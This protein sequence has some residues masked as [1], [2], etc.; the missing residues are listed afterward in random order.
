[1]KMPALHHE[2]FL[3]AGIDGFVDR[4]VRFLAPA[5]AAGAPALVLSSKAKMDRLRRALGA[6]AGAVEHADV[7]DV[8]RNPNWI[9]PVWCDFLDAHAGDER[10]WG[11]GEPA[12]AGRSPAQ[13]VECRH[14]EALVNVA[15]GDR[16]GVDLLC[17]YDTATLP[18]DV[19]EGACATH[20][21]VSTAAES[22]PS[23]SYVDVGDGGSLLREALP[24]PPATAGEIEIAPGDLAA[25]RHHVEQ[26]AVK[27]GLATA[28]ATDIALAV[29]EV[30]T[31]SERHGGGL[32][33]L[34]AWLD[35][36]MLVCEVR[37]GGHLTDPLVGRRRPPP[38]QV[39]GRGLWIA[40]RLCDLVQVRSSAAGT[41]V[42]L[43]KRRDGR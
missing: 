2:A 21:V 8:G 12:W 14:H 34:T 18:P 20:P 38:T 39:G 19:I 33:R 7:T 37:D 43:H 29:D 28:D 31:N 13:L 11:I 22:G 42:R 32:G 6:G 15:L 25:A 16:A 27:V 5:V 36:G 35:A 30:V 40:N 3:Y 9:L 10:V 17:P 1:M 41:V 23:P 26:L 4:A 24:A